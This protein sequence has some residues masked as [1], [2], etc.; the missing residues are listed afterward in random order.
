MGKTAVIALNGQL[1]KKEDDY[2]NILNQGNFFIAADGGSKIFSKLGY[3]PDIIIGDLDSLSV[4]DINY[5]KQQE[6]K[7]IN[8]P[9]EKDETDAELALLYCSENNIN[10]IIFTNTLG[11][12]LD[13]QLANI[14]LLEYALQLGLNAVI[15]EPGLELGIIKKEKKFINYQGKTLS[16]LPL[17]KKVVNVKNIGFK[18][19]L[20]GENLLRYKTRGIS[21]IIKN[22]KARIS[23]DKG[24]LIYIL[25]TE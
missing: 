18:Y 12:R 25:E 17:S 7:F 3:I 5:F 2:K 15:K 13:H 23:L 11:G 20:T 9:V 6:T 22:K 8:F 4:E 24:K 21:N 14:F 19:S 16:I 1:E 10:S